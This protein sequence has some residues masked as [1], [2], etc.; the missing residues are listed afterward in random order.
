MESREIHNNLILEYKQEQEFKKRY[1]QNFIELDDYFKYSGKV[2]KSTYEYSV[3]EN[4][5]NKFDKFHNKNIDK[6][7]RK[8]ARYEKI[9][10][11][12]KSIEYK[13][14]KK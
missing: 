3:Y 12:K 1:K 6:I 8:I 14:Y 13:K 2:E 4:K 11:R 9:I 10:K 5:I 7:T